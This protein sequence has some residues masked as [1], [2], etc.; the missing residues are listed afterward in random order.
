M[1][2]LEV[3]EGMNVVMNFESLCEFAAR[4]ADSFTEPGGEVGD[5]LRYRTGPL[6]SSRY[7]VLCRVPEMYSFESLRTSFCPT[8]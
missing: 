8:V 4:R 1:R 6:M 7:R 5:R 3:D 2:E